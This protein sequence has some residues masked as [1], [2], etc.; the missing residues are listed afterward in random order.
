[1]DLPT[2]KIVFIQEFLKIQSEEAIAQFE[3]L[4]KMGKRV[5]ANNLEPLT[6]EKL[7]DRINKSEANFKNNQFK[8]SD[9][10]LSKY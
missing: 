7:N 9:E 1:M 2:R 3:K 4:L 8:T 10:I 6:L 5:K